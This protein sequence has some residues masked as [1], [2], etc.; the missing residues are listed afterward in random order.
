M[1][2]RSNQQLA[3]PL[4]PNAQVMTQRDLQNMLNRLENLAL[5]NLEGKPWE[6]KRN[7]RGKLVLLDFSAARFFDDLVQAE[8]LVEEIE[9][10]FGDVFTGRDG[11]N[12]VERSCN[13]FKPLQLLQ[14][15]DICLIG[16][17]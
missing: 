12:S 4:D 9:A 5:N 15:V 11:D 8:L 10:A 14:A 13:A 3:R 7:H 1:T 16:G 2:R 17:D 6:F